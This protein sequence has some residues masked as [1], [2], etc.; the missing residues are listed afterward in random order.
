MSG[1][2][3]P[4][5][6]EYRDGYT[7]LLRVARFREDETMLQALARRWPEVLHRTTPQ[8]PESFVPNEKPKIVEAAIQREVWSPIGHL[9]HPGDP[10][11]R[12]ARCGL[13]IYGSHS[14]DER[15]ICSDCQA[16]FAAGDAAPLSG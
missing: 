5:V 11:G 8:Y 16:L 12:T 10:T 9:P 6:I 1:L 2:D 15:A 3:A 13:K 4:V 7:V 14:A